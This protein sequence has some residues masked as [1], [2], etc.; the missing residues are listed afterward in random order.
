MET[1]TGKVIDGFEGR[2]ETVIGCVL[3]LLQSKKSN[4]TIDN[5]LFGMISRSKKNLPFRR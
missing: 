4:C 5:H 3:S 1:I 2:V